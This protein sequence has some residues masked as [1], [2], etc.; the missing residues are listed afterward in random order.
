MAGKKGQLN[1]MD[2]H[3]TTCS[4][5]LIVAC[6]GRN[7]YQLPSKGRNVYQLPSKTVY[8][9]NVFLAM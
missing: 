1:G 9:R 5:A 4:D 6:K 8:V 3:V 2:L 7:I